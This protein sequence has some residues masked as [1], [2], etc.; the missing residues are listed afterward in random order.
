MRHVAFTWFISS[1]NA[2]TSVVGTNG[3]APP[4]NTSTFALI[5]PSPFAGAAVLRPPWK[6]TTPA[7]SSPARA[8]CSDTEPPKQKPIT[9]MRL[10]STPST[11]RSASRP[12]RARATMS[13]G[14]L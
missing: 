3:S 4:C 7:T 5:A 12:A 8:S 9:A 13:G 2:A 11:L 14:S 1:M 10:P 6:E